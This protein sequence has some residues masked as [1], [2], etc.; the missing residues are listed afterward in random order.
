MGRL[1]ALGKRSNLS[2][3]NLPPFSEKPATFLPRTAIVSL[4]IHIISPQ[5]AHNIVDIWWF[6]V[7]FMVVLWWFYVSI[8]LSK[9]LVFRLF[10]HI[11]VGSSVYI[12]I[13][14]QKFY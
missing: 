12:Y 13:S 3:R 6:Y 8:I 14:F 4:S 11:Y 10:M 5:K 2:G 9:V 1:F 7:G